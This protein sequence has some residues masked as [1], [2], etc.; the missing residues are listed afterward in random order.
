MGS[1]LY[2]QPPGMQA[3]FDATLGGFSRLDIPPSTAPP[4]NHPLTP[5]STS[6]AAGGAA[7]ASAPAPAFCSSYNPSA[8]SPYSAPAFSS[9]YNPSTAYPNLGEGRAQQQQQGGVPDRVDYPDALNHGL[10]YSQPEGEEAACA[11]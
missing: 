7:G 3:E 8:A 9:S 2:L 4:P 10:P 11:W 1:Y 5:G 6:T